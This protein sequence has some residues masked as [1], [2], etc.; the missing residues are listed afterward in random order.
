MLVRQMALEWGRDGIRCNT[1]SP[2]PILTPMTAAT[3]ADPDH[4]ARR[5]AGIPLGRIGESHEI[6]GPA[7]FLASAASSMIT[8]ITLDVDGGYLAI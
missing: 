4:R 3:L 2:G 5:S 7:I 1:V 6:V 8:G